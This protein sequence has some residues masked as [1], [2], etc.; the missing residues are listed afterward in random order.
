MRLLRANNSK[1]LVDVNTVGNQFAF[2]LQPCY[3]L[4]MLPLGVRDVRVASIVIPGLLPP[5]RTR[6]AT[7]VESHVELTAGQVFRLPSILEQQRFDV[8]AYDHL[9]ATSP[10]G[11]PISICIAM[12]EDQHL[13]DAVYDPP[14][15]FS[16]ANDPARRIGFF[17]ADCVTP[18]DLGT[19]ATANSRP[20]WVGDSEGMVSFHLDTS[21]AG[22]GN[23]TG[24]FYLKTAKTPTAPAAEWKELVW[25]TTPL[26]AATD[27]HEFYQATRA[28]GPWV[29]WE[30][31]R[32]A[33]AGNR[34]ADITCCKPK[35]RQ[36]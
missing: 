17:Q 31:V 22:A 20:V 28:Y 25:A 6:D 11:E 24:T 15:S 18:L 19:V 36:A 13:M 26:A 9:N 21:G 29:R 5:A 16:S 2:Q 8:V 1:A 10:P 35:G 32:G 3:G 12:L 23:W 14:G 30:W 27:L 7:I 33:G 4:Q 34:Y